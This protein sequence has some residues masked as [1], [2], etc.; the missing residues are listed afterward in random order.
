M[1]KIIVEQLLEGRGLPY[2]LRV[3]SIAHSF[4]GTDRASKG[5]RRAVEELFGRDL[6]ESHRVTHQ[7]PGLL[8]DADLILPMDTNCAKNLPPN[9]TVLFNRF[10]GRD[11][12]VPNPWPDDETAEA[13]K[14]SRQC[15][16]HLHS[17]LSAGL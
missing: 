9:K 4:G 14:R 1:A 16:Q 5:A 8:L 10:F 13:R 17:T 2:R 15:I 11:G 3:M 7:N 12:D 6:L